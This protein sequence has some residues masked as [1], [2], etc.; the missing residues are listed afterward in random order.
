MISKLQDWLQTLPLLSPLEFREIHIDML[1][2]EFKNPITWIPGMMKCLEEAIASANFV[3]SHGIL[4][5]AFALI[6]GD[7]YLGFNYPSCEE[8]SQQFGLT[9]PSL[10][11]FGTKAVPW[12]DPAQ[13][14]Q[15]VDVNNFPADFRQWILLHLEYLNENEPEYRR[16]LWVSPRSAIDF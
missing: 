2:P 11:Y 14:F 6:G 10:Y 8:L 13:K 16:S 3:P 5:G 12:H 15:Q 4:C 7:D 9:P 1:S